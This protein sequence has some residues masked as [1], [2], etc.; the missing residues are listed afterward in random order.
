MCVCVC[1]VCVCVCVNIC[2][3]ICIYIYIYICLYIYGEGAPGSVARA[4]QHTSAYASTRQ[5]TSAYTF[6]FLT[7]FGE[8]APRSVAWVPSASTRSARRL[9]RLGQVGGQ[10][11]QRAGVCSIR[12]HM[13]AYVSICQHTSLAWWEASFCSAKSSRQQETFSYF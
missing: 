5:H 13:S 1:G 9:V 7:S 10:R 6:F 2:M 4:P 11:L 3:Y 12:Q 8:G